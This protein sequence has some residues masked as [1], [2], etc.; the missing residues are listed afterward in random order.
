[1]DAADVGKDLGLE[2]VPHLRGWSQA[3]T[4]IGEIGQLKQ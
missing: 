4:E 3:D 1:M 2:P